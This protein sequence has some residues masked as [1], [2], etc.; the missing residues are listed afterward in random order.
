V[1]FNAFG[2]PIQV[3]GKIEV[4]VPRETSPQQPAIR[5]QETVFHYPV[6]NHPLISQLAQPMSASAVQPAIVELGG[7]L[8]TTIPPQWRLRIDQYID[9]ERDEPIL[10]LHVLSFADTTIVVLGFPHV[11][12]DGG[13]IESLVKEWS[14]V[15]HGRTEAFESLEGAHRDPLNLVR[16]LYGHTPPHIL[17]EHLIDMAALMPEDDAEHPTDPD[18]DISSPE[19]RWRTISLSPQALATLTSQAAETAPERDGHRAF[20]SED[21]V[22][23]AW[24][25]RTVAAILPPAPH[26]P[27]APA[28]LPAVFRPRTA[29]IQNAVQMA[30]SL[31]PA[32]AADVA[33]A[34]PGPLAA[35]MRDA[36]AAQSR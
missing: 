15:L 4:H 32:A 16:G 12:M 31:L 7:I 27:N 18:W 22:V 29:Y 6:N 25:V 34:L 35:R 9:Q 20:C 28:C 5:F 26:P 33:A 19:S 10:G 3:N 24:L 30:W 13:G 8:S 11:M 21:D 23:T 2:P 14:E 1:D 36:L 17:A